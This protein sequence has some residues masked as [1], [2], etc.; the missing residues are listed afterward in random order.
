MKTSSSQLRR[1]AVLTAFS[2]LLPAALCGA[3][4]RFDHVIVIG[5]DGLSPAGWVQA[6]TPTLDRLAAGGAWTRTARGVLPTSSGPNWGSMLAGAG[7]EQHGITSNAREPGTGQIPPSRV[8]P[9]GIFPTIYAVI[10]EQLPAARTAAIYDWAEFH[11]YFEHALVDHMEP[12]RGAVNTMPAAVDY[13]LTERPDFLF[14]HLDDVDGAGHSFGWGSPFYLQTVNLIDGLLADLLAALEANDLA[15]K[16]LLLLISDHGGTGTSHGGSTIAELEIPFI[17]WGAGIAPNRVLPVQVNCTDVAPTVAYALGLEIPNYWLGRP[18][19]SA[20]SDFT[21]LPPVITVGPSGTNVLAGGEVVLSVAFTS[22]SPADL[23]WYRDNQPL[24]ETSPTL[25]L[26]PVFSSDAGSYHVEIVNAHGSAVSSPALVTVITDQPG[27]ADD[28]VL[29]LR[30]DGDYADA[31]GRAHHGVPMGSPAIVEGFIGTGALAFGV[32]NSQFS[33]VTLGTPAELQFGTGQDFSVSFWARLAEW[34]GD[35][36][37]LGNKNWNNGSNQ[38]WVIAT[39]DDGRIQWN[40]GGPPGGRKDFDSEGGVFND[41]EWHHLALSFTRAGSAR[42]WVDGRL[43]HT[44]SL[45]ASLNDVSTP[46]GLAVNIGQD[47]T[48]NYFFSNYAVTG[49]WMD[50]VLIWLRAISTEEAALIHLKGRSGLSATD[51]LP[52]SAPLMRIRR[53]ADGL[54]VDWTAGRLET[55]GE[56]DGDWKSQPA[57][58]PPLPIGA[59]EPRQFFR[60]VQPESQP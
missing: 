51:P 10:R 33:Y 2:L 32:I 60:A 4:R 25:V 31:S 15:D 11:R 37:F 57:A 39:G 27:L 35:P 17:M 48:G 50:D 29:H 56:V 3:E 34:T 28:L 47:G 24:A 45:T 40:L 1:L 38:G 8:G 16:T 21:A 18:V 44:G 30:F 26:S 23:R 52:V 46:S 19:V 9:G 5:I 20:F 49:G 13:F 55:A 41:G 14:V 22:E 42:T 12:V 43:V 6:E 36:A 58:Q 53:E 54:K 7:P 59:N